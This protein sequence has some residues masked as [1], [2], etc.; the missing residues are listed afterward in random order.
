MFT[1]EPNRGGPA[2]HKNPN[3]PCRPCVAR[4]REKEALA[5][6]DGAGR[7]N[8]DASDSSKTLNTALPPTL[9]HKESKSLRARVAEWVEIKYKNPDLNNTE[10]AEQMGISRQHL[11]YVI[12][13]ASKE[14]WLK[15]ADPLERIEHEII[16][17]VMDNLSRYLDERDKQVTI[18]TAKNT[19]FKTYQ[20]SMGVGQAPQT[21]LALKIETAPVDQVKV[22]TGA[23]VGVARTLALSEN[24]DAL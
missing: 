19:I 15:I 1:E 14:G 9:Y 22:V 24:E 18:E 13:K 17:K 2:L 3:C 10:I 20:A 6:T 23:I 8:L 5:L 21:V 7:R 11:Q 16:P 12:G 4:R